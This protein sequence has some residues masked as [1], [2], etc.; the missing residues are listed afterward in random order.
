MSD[1]EEKQIHCRE[2]NGYLWSVSIYDKDVPVLQACPYQ[3]DP[4]GHCTGKLPQP[5]V[6]PPVSELAGEERGR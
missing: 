2:C 6:K 5:K 4:M 1:P 3:K